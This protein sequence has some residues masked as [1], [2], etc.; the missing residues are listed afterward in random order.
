MK[1]HW[2]AIV[3]GFVVAFVLAVISGLLIAG[4]DAATLV[5]SW[6][7][8]GIVGGLV[9]GHMAG[10]TVGTGAVHGGIA[11]VLGSL[12]TLAV[13]TFTTLLFAGVVATFGV[14]AVGLLL[15]AFYAIPGALGGAIGSWAK[16]RRAARKTTGARA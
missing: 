7:M 13:V 9:A 8:I 12:I 16:G 1:L 14:L 6:A 10:G 4:T 15:L 11:T 3:T 2:I 5:A